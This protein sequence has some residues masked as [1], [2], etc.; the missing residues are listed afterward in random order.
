MGAPVRLRLPGRQTR[1][2]EL[3][4]TAVMYYLRVI[5]CKNYPR[6]QSK[7]RPAA[8]AALAL[9]S[10]Q[11]HSRSEAADGTATFSPLFCLILVR[12]PARQGRLHLARAV[13]PPPR[14]RAKQV[15][16]SAHLQASVYGPA[17]AFPGP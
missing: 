14:L 17:R 6:T 2:A 10:T 12:P 13:V 11:A 3:A 4:A 16:Y 5:R 1:I 7:A 15:F 9:Q 8:R